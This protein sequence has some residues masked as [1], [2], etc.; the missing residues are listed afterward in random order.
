M[1]NR[2]SSAT[3][4]AVKCDQNVSCAAEDLHDAGYVQTTLQPILS[5]TARVLNSG[6]EAA[7]QEVLEV[8]IEVAEVHPRFFR[9]QL[10][11]VVSAM[12]QVGPGPHIHAPPCMDC[13]VHV[14]VSVMT[15]A[16]HG[17]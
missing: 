16:M 7:A 8:L 15:G 13:H 6:D 5:A 11:E 12:L 1:G 9:R 10:S 14:L 3:L 4:L 17:Q 2:C